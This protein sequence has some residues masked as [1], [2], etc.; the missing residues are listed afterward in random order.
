MSEIIETN[1]VEGTTEYKQSLYVTFLEAAPDIAKHALNGWE[2]DEKNAYPFQHYTGLLEVNYFKNA[3]TIRRAAD[4][5]QAAVEGKGVMTKEKR[6]EIMNKA[7]ET[8]MANLEKKKAAA[9]E[10]A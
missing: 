2:V 10:K 6:V 8:R 1:V 5:I 7:R 4:K 3:E 9:G